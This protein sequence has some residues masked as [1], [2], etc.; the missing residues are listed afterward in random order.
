MNDDRCGDGLRLVI[1]TVDVQAAYR[2]E[3]RAT[4]LTEV[5]ISTSCI[6]FVLNSEVIRRNG[7]CFKHVI[8]DKVAHS[9][10]NTY[11]L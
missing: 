1:G 4:G 6:L 7:E 2:Q 5:I 9:K 8:R 3:T 11:F 10:Q